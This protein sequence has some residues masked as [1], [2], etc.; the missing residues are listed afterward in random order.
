MQP[1]PPPAAIDDIL[2]LLQLKAG[3]TAL[4]IAPFSPRELAAQAISLPGNETV[5]N[6]NKIAFR[7]GDR[8]PA[9]L[10]GDARRVRQILRLLLEN[11]IEFTRDGSIGLDIGVA[12]DEGDRVRLRFAVSD[13][14]IG[15]DKARQAELF[16]VSPP[17]DTNALR[18]FG[19]NGRGL[20]ICR[21]L[22]ER[23]GG[24]IGVESDVGYGSVFWFEIP[25][26]R[27]ARPLA[28]L[29]NG[30]SSAAPRRRH[31]RILVAEDVAINQLVFQHYLARDGHLCDVVADGRAALAALGNAAYDIVLMD[32]HM[33]EMD[34][35]ATT[36][37]IRALPAPVGQIPIVM[38]TA[39]AMSGDRA[40]YLAA[41][42][43]DCIAKPVDLE[44]LRGALARNADFELDDLA[45]DGSEAVNAAAAK[46]SARISAAAAA[47]I[48]ALLARATAA[49]RKFG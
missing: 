25:F 48:E 5:R 27:A 29:A 33:P 6:G 12:A 10:D 34:G 40:A 1:A 26:A 47:E 28:M 11:A 14:G 17:T 18:G 23:M 24:T 49:E 37:G 2:D 16:P 35:L 44:S 30:G 13:S 36:R 42:A 9:R 45:D 22:A 15:I 38:V 41:G 8:V 32:V 43:N 31:L 39:D 19:G 4:D 7:V 20:A 46:A 21:Q 3:Q